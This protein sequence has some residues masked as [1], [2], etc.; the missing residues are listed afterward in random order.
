M[1]MVK[2]ASIL[3]DIDK[4][5]VTFIQNDPSITYTK[6][7]EKVNRSQPTIGMRIK[8]LE[9]QGIIKFQAGLD[10]KNC[11]LAKVT[12]Q[13]SDPIGV[14][15]TIKACPY[16][17][18]GYRV[19]GL[20]NFEIIIA[21]SNIKDLDKIVNYHFRNNN[22]IK[23][24]DIAIISEIINEFVVPFDLELKTCKCLQH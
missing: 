1:N 7:A 9:D 6:I 11:N 3:D 17:I 13:T 22:T 10:L 14:E 4:K 5:I 2:E 23:N 8:K 12:F 20:K 15:E 19:S 16:L 21:Y 18:H 24:V